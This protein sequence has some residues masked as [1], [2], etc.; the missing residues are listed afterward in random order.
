MSKSGIILCWFVFLAC[1]FP[2]SAAAA[3]ESIVGFGVMGDSGSDEYRADDSRGGAYAETTLNWLELLE[4]Y[5]GLNFG[6]WGTRDF[7]RRSGYEYNWA[8]SGA[9]AA[10]VISEGQAAGLAQQVGQ[11][12]VSLVLL[13]VGVNDF[14]LWNGTYRAI[15]DGTL[16]G[17]GL[18]DKI[19]DIVANIQLALDTVRAAG[20][21]DVFVANLAD[22]GATP[23]F[24]AEFPDA[25]KRQAVTNAIVAVNGGILAMAAA[26]GITVVDIYALAGTLLSHVDADGN[27]I[28]GDELISMTSAGDEPHHVLLG[29]NE[30]GGT[31]FEGVLANYIL[32]HL[33]PAGYS[34]LRFTDQELLTNAGIVSETQD[35]SPPT[36]SITNPPNGTVLSRE[37][38]VSADAS[39][40]VAVLG[41]QFKLDNNNLGSE[42]TAPPYSISWDTTNLA[43]GPHVLSAVAR[44]GS[45]KTTTTSITVNVIDTTPPTVRITSPAHGS[46]VIG[47]MTV[48]AS[49]SDN[50]GVVGV[51]FFG[52]GAALGPEDTQPPF[53]ITVQTNW[54]QNGPLALTAIGRDASGNTR[55]SDPIV[56]TV[57]NP[58]PDTTAPTVAFTN[59]TNNA[60]VSGI[61]TVTVSASDNVSVA[62]VQFKLDGSNLASEDMSA[63]FSVSWN[64]ST[65][66]NGTHTLAAFARDAAGNVASS[67]V[68]VNVSNLPSDTRYPSAYSVKHGSYQSGNAQSLVSN[69]NEYLVIK[70]AFLGLNAI[71]KTELEFTNVAIPISSWSFSIILKTST[72]GIP[73]TIY[74]YNFASGAW[75]RTTSTEIGTGE[76]TRSFSFTAN[77]MNYIDP[78]GKVRLMCESNKFLRSHSLYLEM[79]KL[80]VN[81]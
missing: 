12:K 60:T 79:A 46:Q 6:E 32:D 48:E 13:M 51:T 81:H 4:R 38:A 11:G 10:G 22:R 39:D 63:P 19:N 66:S 45:G 54:T 42:D 77:G 68:T 64:T 75:D 41:V 78:V 35:T 55:T 49:A 20:V 76:T 15:Y 62:G 58:L 29:D 16:I 59:P 67:T 28:V 73:V 9:T 36:V 52:A 31:V 24:R 40:D 72:A 65:S 34:V 21:V 17:T 56:I 7:P 47:L 2:L 44:D 14:A 37:V 27:L 26:R 5:R 50:I 30:H 74:A 23:A 33:N 69:N 61:L 25:A 18:D 8:R 43:P 57:N 70:S 80:T 3:E 1:G 53:R 71:S